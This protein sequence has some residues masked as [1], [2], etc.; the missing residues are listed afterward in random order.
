VGPFGRCG[1]GNC[2]IN[3]ACGAFWQM[4]KCLEMGLVGPFVEY[5]LW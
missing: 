3:W 4:G 5:G 1:V 2:L